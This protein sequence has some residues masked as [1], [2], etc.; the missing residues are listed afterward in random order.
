[1][2]DDTTRQQGKKT[3]MIEVRVS[4]ETKRAFLEACRG[5]GRTASDVIREG[6]EDFIDHARRPQPVVEE[7]SPAKVLALIPKAVRRKRYA[8]AGVAAVGLS[9]MAALPSAAAPDLAAAFKKLDADGDGVLTDAEFAKREGLGATQMGLRLPRSTPR[10][11]EEKAAD[12]AKPVIFLIPAPADG[13]PLSELMRDVRLQG[14]GIPVRTE[15]TM[16][17]SFAAFDANKNGKVDMDEFLARQKVMLSNGFARLDKDGNGGLDATEYSGL[18]TKF[19]LYPSDAVLELGVAA[20]Y[21]PVVSAETIEAGFARHDADKDGKV[22]L[23]E[24]LPSQ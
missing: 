3:E 11:E 24:Y 13:K 19:I 2:T 9:L 18:G 10:T 14:L 21:G 12:A 4:H 6:I 5:A 17:A 16:K 1:M 15:E 8:A 7:R 23:K 20:Q 22:S